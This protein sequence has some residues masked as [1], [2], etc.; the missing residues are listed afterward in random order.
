MSDQLEPREGQILFYTTA[1]GDIRLDV[2][3]AS[4][5][6]W[7][8]QKRMAELFEADRSVITKHLRNI[9][10]EGELEE[11]AVSAIFAHTAADGKSYQTRFYNLDASPRTMAELMCGNEVILL[12]EEHPFLWNSESS[13]ARSS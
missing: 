3:F 1:T 5:M 9:F 6:A 10:S 11:R 12:Y 7:L 13:G 4:E 2:L 8:T